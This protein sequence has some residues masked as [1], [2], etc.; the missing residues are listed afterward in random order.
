MDIISLLIGVS[1]IA[2][3]IMLDEA[4][5]GGAWIL[6]RL[7]G[8]RRRRKMKNEWIM[9]NGIAKK[10]KW[11][12]PLEIT[13][14]GN[15]RNERDV[16]TTNEGELIQVQVDELEPLSLSGAI[17]Y[18][19]KAEKDIYREDNIRLHNAL[20]AK[21]DELNELTNDML[22]FGIKTSEGFGKIRKNIGASMFFPMPQQQ[23]D[24]GGL[25]GNRGNAGEPAEP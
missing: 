10:G 23:N 4:L 17:V 21:N 3:I 8:Y 15:I 24:M 25:F 1:A 2:G 19:P 6:N 20:N 11:I 18:V 22:N 5:T 14:A 7:S 12:E 9:H 13:Y 16:I